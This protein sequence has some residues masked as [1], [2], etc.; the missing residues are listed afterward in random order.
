M[1]PTYGEI[2]RR[3][4]REF[5]KRGEWAGLPMPLPGLGLVV[6]P[7]H[8]AAAMIA[9]LQ[10][11]VEV[12][13]P[14]ETRACSA[15]DLGWRIV[16]EWRGRTKHDVTG[17]VF[18]LRHEDGRTRWGVASDLV[19][20]NKHLFGPLETFDAWH[21]DTECTAIDRLAMLVNERQ[22]AAYVLTASF[23]ESS[24]R[25]G[26][27]YLF[28]R[29]RP[30]VVLSGHG[31]RHDYFSERRP[32]P[33]DSMHIVAC[34]CLHPIAYYANTFAGAMVPTDD[35]IAHLMLMRGDEHLFWR[36]ANQHHPLDP[37]SGL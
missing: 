10:R 34:L 15:D 27:T 23:L 20:R 3:I 33:D 17:R 31:T 22:F 21:L 26:L 19:T 37:E 12:D 1:G 30:T 32:S 25:S 16:N 24:K 2:S 18:I 7:K 9:D 36:R 13:T 5:E 11:A 6:E 14:P 4:N 8:P 29:C 28:R 35:V